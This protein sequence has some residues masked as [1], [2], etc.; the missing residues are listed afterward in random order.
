MSF[1]NYYELLQ[2]SP[3]A[4]YETVQ[5]V[6]R[7][8]AARYHPDNVET[9]DPD[10]FVL[11]N[12]AHAVLA[13]A[14][15]RAKYDLELQSHATE[16]IEIFNSREFIQGI[17]GEVHRRMG[18]LCLLYNRRRSDPEH[19]GM[20]MLQMEALMSLPRE[21]LLFTIWYLKEKDQIRQTDNSDLV[22]TAVGADHVESNLPSHK[23]LYNLLKAAENGTA[24]AGPDRRAQEPQ[25]D[26]S[27]SA[28]TA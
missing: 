9:G 28:R 20:S 2:I 26:E 5:R 10:K 17:D 13:S 16:P 15:D 11:L 23:L 24:P 18:I 19:P 22:I 3:N 14:V 4:E 21:H 8:L 12:Q 7:M 25:S 6:F 27:A 1:V